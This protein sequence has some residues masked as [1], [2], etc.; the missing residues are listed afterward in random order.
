MKIKM[1]FIFIAFMIPL[2]AIT[3]ADEVLYN[4]MNRLNNMDRYLIIEIEEINKKGN[5]KNKRMKYWAKWNDLSKKHFIKIQYEKPDNLFGVSYWVN[6]DKNGKENKWI[7]MPFSGKLKNITNKKNIN[8]GEFDL[9]ELEIKIKDID[10]Y[11]NKIIDEDLVN[12]RATIVIVSKKNNSKG[13]V[14]LIKKI[15]VDKNN[16]FIHKVL[17]L[18]K[19]SKQIREIKLNKL[20]FIDKVPFLTQIFIND[21]KKKKMI[22]INFS[23]ISLSHIKND[24]IFIPMGK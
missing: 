16:F 23:D 1:Y 19:K 22:N 18:N 15:W 7:T 13:K 10:D 12:G 17:Y 21:F 8:K 9:S 24:Q 20:V 5:I 3:D 11:H 4:V 14:V 2:F 6:Y